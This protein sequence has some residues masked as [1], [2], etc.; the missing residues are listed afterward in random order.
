MS[1]KKEKPLWVV[2]APIHASAHIY[3]RAESAGQAV[4]LAE[5]ESYV[6]LCHQCA[7]GVELGDPMWHEAVA[8]PTDHAPRYADV[9][10]DEEDK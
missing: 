10:G 5:R 2:L 1:E 6:G 7:G 9:L 8:E 4:D 3:V